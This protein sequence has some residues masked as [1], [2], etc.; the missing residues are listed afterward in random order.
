MKHFP[1]F[2]KLYETLLRVSSCDPNYLRARAVD[3]YYYTRGILQP[4]PGSIDVIPLTHHVITA[5]GVPN[6]QPDVA[7][8]VD[9]RGIGE[10]VRLE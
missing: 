10:L 3:Y 7:L 5:T 1:I 8:V 6:A 4:F 9:R 2:Y